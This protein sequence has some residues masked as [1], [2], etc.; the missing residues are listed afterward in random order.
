MVNPD[1]IHAYTVLG[2]VGAYQPR[3]DIVLYAATARQLYAKMW[4]FLKTLDPKNDSHKEYK[5]RILKYFKENNIEN[6]CHS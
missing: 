2:L 1:K 5:K 3:K 6:P 4:E